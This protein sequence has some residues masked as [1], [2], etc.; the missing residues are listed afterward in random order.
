MYQGSLQDRI[1]TEIIHLTEYEKTVIG[2]RV[3]IAT[4]S[5]GRRYCSVG[6]GLTADEPKS[7]NP[8]AI[9]EGYVDQSL[10]LYLVFR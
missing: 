10:Q 7:P 2:L 1:T 3:P 4:R 5:G 8:F 6:K 9:I